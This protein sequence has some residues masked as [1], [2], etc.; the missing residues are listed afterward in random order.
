[1]DHTYPA[2]RTYF[3]V[4][5]AWILGVLI[6]GA[7]MP[8]AIAPPTPPASASSVYEMP[9]TG[10]S[11]VGNAMAPAPVTIGSSR[12]DS[13]K[14]VLAYPEPIA[15]TS[16]TAL[17]VQPADIPPEAAPAVVLRPSSSFDVAFSSG[18]LAHFSR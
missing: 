8:G 6:V 1:M 13:M 10:L 18:R 7:F 17:T 4:L 12:A 15:L 11:Q 5:L 14:D 9:P 16:N 2:N 3:A